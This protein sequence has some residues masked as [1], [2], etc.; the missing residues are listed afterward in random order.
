MNLEE[1]D[2]LVYIFK[3]I[4]LKNRLVVM[5]LFLVLVV[6]VSGTNGGN[7]RN[8]NSDQI[9]IYYEVGKDCHRLACHDN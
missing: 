6:K 2:F 5:W 3:K 8:N 7:I 1:Y 4:K 9:V